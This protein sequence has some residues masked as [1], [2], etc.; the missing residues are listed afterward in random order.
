MSLNQPILSLSCN[1]LDP[2]EQVDT[3]NNLATMWT[4]MKYKIYTNSDQVLNKHL[5][6]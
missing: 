4:G 2:I 3:I 1:S 6:L 5:S